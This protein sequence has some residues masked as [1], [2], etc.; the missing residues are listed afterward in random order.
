MSEAALAQRLTVKADMTLPMKF[1]LNTP[2]VAGS[3]SRGPGIIAHGTMSTNGAFSLQ[4]KC[5][6]STTRSIC[7]PKSPPR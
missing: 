6:R 1:P 5:W 7:H 2:R 3:V 4:M